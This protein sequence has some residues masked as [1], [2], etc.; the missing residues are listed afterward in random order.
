M[1][2]SFLSPVWQVTWVVVRWAVLVTTMVP[3]AAI[4]GHSSLQYTPFSSGISSSSSVTSTTTTLSSSSSSPA[5]G[6]GFSQN[7][8]IS[9]P[10]SVSSKFFSAA[11][12]KWL[13]SKFTLSCSSSCG[14]FILFI[15]LAFCSICIYIC[16][17]IFYCFPCYH[18]SQ[19]FTCS[20]STAKCLSSSSLLLQWR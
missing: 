19:L 2:S 13:L 7:V 17:C 11:C 1:D 15:I 12:Y 8:V 10:S 6:I 14:S 20:G 5:M 3:S 16:T 4:P 18:P 9:L